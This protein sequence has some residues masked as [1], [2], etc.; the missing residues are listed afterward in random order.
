M[1]DRTRSSLLDIVRFGGEVQDLVTSRGKD[2]FLS[3]RATQLVAEALIHR[4]G[5]AVARL[6]PDVVR[7]HP[8]V[9]WRHMKQMRH[10]VA[11]QDGF[12]DYT[13]VWRALATN[14]PDDLAVIRGLLSQSERP[15]R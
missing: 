3:D 9:A 6:D 1:R 8:E 4:I 10:V 2:Q 15:Q 7:S 12:I 13:L 14:L 11:H 5:E